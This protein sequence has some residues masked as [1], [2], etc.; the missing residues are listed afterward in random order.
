MASELTIGGCTSGSTVVA[1]IRKDADETVWNGSAFVTWSDVTLAAGTYDIALTEQGTSGY[2][3]GN[4]PATITDNGN[5][6]VTYYTR[7]LV[8]TT[9]TYSHSYETTVTITWVGGSAEGTAGLGWI[10]KEEY[11]QQFGITDTTQ[12]DLID[13]TILMVSAALNV[14][15]GRTVKATDVAKVYRGNNLWQYSTREFPINSITQIT[16]DYMDASPTVYAG[17][18]FYA[19][20]V[21]TIY[22]KPQYLTT[23]YAFGTYFW[24][25][26]ANVGYTVVPD[27]LKL[28]CLLACRQ[29][30]QSSDPDVL[31]T[32]KSV[33]NVTIKYD[34]VQAL[35][36]D[37]FSGVKK[38]L[39][40]ERVPVLI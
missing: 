38:M 16:M 30:I 28:A 17:T 11:K 39:D 35:S 40:G 6:N 32:T 3:V 8:T 18:Y 14:Y 20:S 10:T 33:G 13:E 9:P 2:F 31:V 24:K 19:N 37:I 12:D 22:W 7:T 5:Y 26:E 21:G 15:L 27:N 1:V 4:F 36:N 34:A 25:L 29:V 23:A